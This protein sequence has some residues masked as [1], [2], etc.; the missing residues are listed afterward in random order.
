[1]ARRYLFFGHYSWRFGFSPQ[2]GDSF[3]VC[4]VPEGPGDVNTILLDDHA[5]TGTEYWHVRSD[6]APL[7]HGYHAD[8]ALTRLLVSEELTRLMPGEASAPLLV[9]ADA[10]DATRFFAQLRTGGRD[11][12]AIWCGEW[13]GP[14][15]PSDH[16]QR[17]AQTL[18]RG[19]RHIEASR[20]FLSNYQ[21]YFRKFKPGTEIEHKLTVTSEADIYEL[22]VHFRNLIGSGI[23]S[24]YIWEYR[25]DF[26]QWDFD[27]HLYEVPG[28][29][30][31][32][33]YIS[34]MPSADGTAVVKRKWFTA[35]AIERRESKWT[36]VTLAGSGTEYIS[37]RF[38]VVGRYLGAFRRTRFDIS[39]ESIVTGNVY[40]IMIDRCRFDRDD[41]PDLCQIEVEYLKSRTL[42]ASAAGALRAEMRQIVDATRGELDRLGI[43]HVESPLS[44][45]TYM[46]QLHESATGQAPGA[47]GH[48]L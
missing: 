44:K 2:P 4:Q 28:P 17:L 35:D 18:S 13:V 6:G 9:A 5:L 46:R 34:L 10:E 7:G 8:C 30:E 37:Q 24:N 14:N 1:M 3:V 39:L 25:D 41:W 12:L 19:L 22:S 21:L 45:L 29:P 15:R 43:D 32:A 33:G 23:F 16:G 40:A 27:N 48:P 47:S 20:H 11:V 26:E 31:E 42:R 38:G 36:G